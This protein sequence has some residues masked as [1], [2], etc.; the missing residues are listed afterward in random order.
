MGEKG[1]LS[2]R[3]EDFLRFF[4]CAWWLIRGLTSQAR[5]GW[6]FTFVRFMAVF[7]I[8]FF[9]QIDR[10]HL[11]LPKGHHR[12]NNLVWVGLEKHCRT[13][14]WNCPNYPLD[15]KGPPSEWAGTIRLGFPNS[16]IR[17]SSNPPEERGLFAHKRWPFKSRLTPGPSWVWLPLSCSTSQTAVLSNGGHK[18]LLGEKVRHLGPLR[19]SFGLISH[20]ALFPLNLWWRC[21][22]TYRS[23]SPRII[24]ITISDG[25]TPNR[26]WP[27]LAAFSVRA[28]VVGGQSE[29][30]SFWIRTCRRQMTAM[31]YGA[32]G[33]MA[34]AAWVQACSLLS[35]CMLLNFCIIV[36]F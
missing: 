14:L 9:V 2:Y 36:V 1:E 7:Y 24:M 35:T 17:L 23:L 27:N 12:E 22:L 20:L 18:F 28:D 26:I 21:I 8:L 19:A 4:S 3:Y 16:P 6:Q 5:Y 25:L 11:I 10:C 34:A 13:G 32:V 33:G 30:E 31:G 15:A 29:L